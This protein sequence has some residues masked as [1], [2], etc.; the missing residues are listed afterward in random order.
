MTFL[1]EET[2]TQSDALA[3]VFAKMNELPRNKL[4]PMTDDQ[5]GMSI[6]VLLSDDDSI[7]NM[8][9]GL[10][11]HFPLNAFFSRMDALPIKYNKRLKIWIGVL[12]LD[13][14]IG[15][16]ILVGYYLQWFAHSN[17][18]TELTLDYVMEKIF[19]W[20]IFSK[21]TVHEYWDN[22]KVNARPDNLVDHHSACASFMS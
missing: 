13:T 18:L 22:Q 1:P 5:S 9:D 20:G 16:L 19:P 2:I 3:K 10:N 7:D 15:G 11:K 17:N 4:V 8:Y 6:N 14:N 12:F 21:E